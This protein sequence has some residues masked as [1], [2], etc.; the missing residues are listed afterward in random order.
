MIYIK[1]IF[2]IDMDLIIFKY[3]SM[4]IATQIEVTAWLLGRGL[5]QI[6]FINQA[7]MP[8]IYYFQNTFILAVACSLGKFYLA[9]KY[10][11]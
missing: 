4:E 8:V 5:V 2:I 3:L 7:V 9:R 10:Y 11:S 6:I 1:N